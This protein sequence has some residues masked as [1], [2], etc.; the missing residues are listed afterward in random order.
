M[1]LEIGTLPVAFCTKH[2]RLPISPCDSFLGA[3]FLMRGIHQSQIIRH[4]RRKTTIWRQ[5]DTYGFSHTGPGQAQQVAKE[6]SAPAAATFPVWRC[7]D[8]PR[9]GTQRNCAWRSAAVR[10]GAKGW[11][12]RSSAAH[13][14]M[15]QTP[16][17][18]RSRPP[19]PDQGFP[20]IVCGVVGW[21]AS[22]SALT[23]LPSAVHL[24]T[25]QTYKRCIPVLRT[26][27]GLSGG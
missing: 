17:A 2:L 14:C 3:S 26:W 4:T 18:L 12:G 15:C 13:S 27:S 6:C 10:A 24:W 22:A 23:S 1:V 25:C 16:S 9:P 21:R 19:E 8:P 20:C 7:A 11:T 5:R